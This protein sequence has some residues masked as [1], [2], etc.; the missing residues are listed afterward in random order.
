MG[1]IF[2]EIFHY[3]RDSKEFDIK[4]KKFE[5]PY[6]FKSLREFPKIVTE[7]TRK[8][9]SPFFPNVVLFSTL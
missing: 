3:S 6:K 1:V 5:E 7:L 2:R 4:H 9:V 8:F